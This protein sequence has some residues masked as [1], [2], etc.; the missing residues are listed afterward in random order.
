[1]SDRAQVFLYYDNPH[2]N[3]PSYDLGL[4]RAELLAGDKHAAALGAEEELKAGK[5]RN[6]GEMSAGSPWLW[7]ALGLVVVVLLVVVAKMLPKA[8]GGTPA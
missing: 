2:V 1:V 3:P 6:Q 8:A 5:H 7:A 4:V